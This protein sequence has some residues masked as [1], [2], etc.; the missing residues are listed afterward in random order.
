VKI[1]LIQG[2]PD[3]RGGRFCHALAE[4]YARGA[5]GAGHE[6][7]LVDVA[8]LDF[9]LLRSAL[10]WQEAAAAEPICKAQDTIDWAQHLVIVFPLWLGDM[11]ALLKGFFE[12][13]LRPGFAIGEAGEGRIGKKLLKGRSARLIVTMGM[14]AFFYRIFYRAHSVKSLKRNI[15]EFCGISPVRSTLIG[16]VDSAAGRQIALAK[17]RGLGTSGK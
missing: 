4:S 10:E 12:Q 3:A 6:V 1:A 11:P 17:V 16:T 5:T 8:Q 13:A 14:P 9:P 15:L 7:R 2:H